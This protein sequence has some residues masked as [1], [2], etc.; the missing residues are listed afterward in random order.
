MAQRPLGQPRS[1]DT[2][3]SAEDWHVAGSSKGY[4]KEVSEVLAVCLPRIGTKT[5]SGQPIEHHKGL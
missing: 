4:G 3:M 1:I 2:R 5:L